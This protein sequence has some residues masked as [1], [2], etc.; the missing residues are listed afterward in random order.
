[1][2]IPGTKLF[3]GNISERVQTQDLRADFEKYGRVHEVKICQGYGFVTYEDPRCAHNAVEVGG[4]LLTGIYGRGYLYSKGY[5][6]AKLCWGK[7]E[8]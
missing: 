6:R 1:M 2:E 4:V 7:V 8:S 3:V 5:G